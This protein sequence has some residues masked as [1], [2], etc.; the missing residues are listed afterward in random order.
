MQPQ[1]PCLHLRLYQKTHQV[2]GASFM[3]RYGWISLQTIPVSTPSD[4]FS[5]M[6]FCPLGEF[7]VSHLS[8]ETYEHKL[9]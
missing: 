1:E 9:L 3:K 4:S 8:V 7:H 6:F 2:L 5:E